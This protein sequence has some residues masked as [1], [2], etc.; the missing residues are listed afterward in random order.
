M[1][2]EARLRLTA[3]DKGSTMKLIRRLGGRDFLALGRTEAS[4][5]L[6][7]GVALESCRTK[8]R[9]SPHPIKQFGSSLPPPSAERPEAGSGCGRKA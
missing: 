4:D 2:R 7:A 5:T 1:G 8:A 9:H 3:P 6:S